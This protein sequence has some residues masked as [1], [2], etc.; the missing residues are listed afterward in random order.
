MGQVVRQSHCNHEA[1]LRDA[2]RRDG[3]NSFAHR[4]SVALHL[5]TFGP[6][7]ATLADASGRGAQLQEAVAPGH[8]LRFE[9]G[10]KPT[11][12]P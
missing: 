9:P 1:T 6:T 5:T 10:S 12:R 2:S 11:C 4:S 8:G 3:T 7:A